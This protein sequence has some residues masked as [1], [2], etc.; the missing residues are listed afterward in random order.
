MNKYFV[1]FFLI[2]LAMPVVWAQVKELE[3]KENRAAWADESI[4]IILAARAKA[5]A[6]PEHQ[7]KIAEI[8]ANVDLMPKDGNEQDLGV[9]QQG[10]DLSA[11]TVTGSFR[12]RVISQ[13]VTDYCNQKRSEATTAAQKQVYEHRCSIVLGF[14]LFNAAQTNGDLA[15]Q[16]RSLAGKIQKLIA[17]YQQLLSEAK[18]CRQDDPETYDP[19]IARLERIMVAYQKASQHYL[20]AAASLEK[21]KIK[22]GKQAAQLEK[23]V[24]FSRMANVRIAEILEKQAQEIAEYA[25]KLANFKF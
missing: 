25:E 17:H 20:S 9:F 18:A 11:T 1:S 24:Y 15:Q 14:I 10:L 6:S 21:A 13:D 16:M 3:V 19:I 2:C 5:D 4:A 12:L 7:A 22:F 23:M 8:K